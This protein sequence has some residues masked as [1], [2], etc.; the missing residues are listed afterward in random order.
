M[1]S[2]L[3][4][5]HGIMCAILLTFLAGLFYFEGKWSAWLVRTEVS[6][7]SHP[8]GESKCYHLLFSYTPVLKKYASKVR[9]AFLTTKYLF[10]FKPK[11]YLAWGDSLQK[12]I[13]QGI[14]IRLPL[15]IF[16][17]V[18]SM[19]KCVHKQSIKSV[20]SIN[21]VVHESSQQQT[22][23]I[24]GL[25]KKKIVLNPFWRYL[26]WMTNLLSTWS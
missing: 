9:L 25:K 1:V 17:E 15:I 10:K 3:V 16:S 18:R 13:P 23:V 7:C 12:V 24:S 19:L 14:W 26:K 21:R 20:V 22:K 6:T 4:P 5:V 2:V 11:L 8:L